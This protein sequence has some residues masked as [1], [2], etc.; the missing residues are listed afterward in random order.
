MSG[1]TEDAETGLELGELQMEVM[2]VLWRDGEAST[3]AV[4]AAIAAERPIA[5]TT[6]ATVLARLARRG[7]VVAR[8]EARQ[9]IYRPATSESAV[10]RGMVSDLVRRLFDGN[11]TALLAHLV[12]EQEVAPGDLA[13]VEALLAAAGSDSDTPQGSGR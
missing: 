6:V 4:A 1:G 11:A 9:L 5:H 7:L 10:R 3:A 12:S 8:R 2:R 13:R